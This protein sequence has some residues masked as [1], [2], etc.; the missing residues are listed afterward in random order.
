MKQPGPCVSE[1]HDV[2]IAGAGP[3]G[4]IA[5]YCLA[6]AGMRVIIVDQLKARPLKIGEILPGAACRLLAVLGLECVLQPA[7]N[8]V[9]ARAGGRIFAWGSEGP[10]REDALSDPYGAGVTLDRL[11]FDRALRHEAF[12]AGA[13]FRRANVVSIE[14]TRAGWRCML[15]DGTLVR[16]RWLIDA[17]GRSARI[18]QLLGAERH[19]GKPLVGLYGTAAPSGDVNLNRTVVETLPDGWLYAGRLQDHL[20]AVGFHTEPREAALIHK[21]PGRIIDIAGKATVFSSIFGRL[22]LDGGLSTRDARSAWMAPCSGSSWIAC[23]DAALSFDPVA[24]QGLFNALRT[25]MAAADELQR[26]AGEQVS[27]AYVDEIDRVAAA[28]KERRRSLY[29]AEARWKERPFWRMHGA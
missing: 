2:V 24:G 26:T 28:Y 7:A 14:R 29:C 3:A 5:A 8:A 16:G 10:I 21:T 9:L 20:W 18:G 13:E 17:T 15:A 11:R 23:G 1:S 25:G 22:K 4:A 27:Q 12:G 19:R 6:R